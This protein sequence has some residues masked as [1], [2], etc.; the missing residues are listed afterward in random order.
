LVQVNATV[1]EKA[2][3]LGP[4]RSLV[5]IVTPAAGPADERSAAPAIVI[6]NSGI[7]HRVGA[8]RLSVT[9]ARSA[10][11]AGFAA[12]R[13]DL[14]GIGDSEP[15]GDASTPLEAAMADIKE[16][17]DSA[18]KIA[19]DGRFI[20]VGLC[21]GAD[22]SVVYAGTDPRVI[23]IAILDPS[24]PRTPGYFVRHYGMRL[25][26]GASWLNVISGRHPEIRALR[27][28]MAGDQGS[29][30]AG[31]P[32][33]ESPEVRAFLARSYG[34]AIKAGVR[35]LAVLTTGSERQHNYAGQLRDAFPTVRF[36][37]RLRT[38]YF[39]GVDHTF[40]SEES[41]ARVTRLIVQWAGSVQAG[42][43]AAQG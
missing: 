18:V 27:K 35:I 38:D 11:A 7:I 33:L 34:N 13:F 1:K 31:G 26:R 21:S 20:L 12:I 15:R 2:V 10:A 9:L 25:L 43:R 8:N 22:H 39:R 17:L 16:A 24:I 40:M 6:L 23:G 19:G 30:K 4:R 28:R 42:S 29:I 41:R 36:G 32:S 14:S 5:G 37:D 3:L